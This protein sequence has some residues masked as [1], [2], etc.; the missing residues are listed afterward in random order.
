MQAIDLEIDVTEAVGL[1]GPVRVVA[2]VVLPDDLPDDP[3][4]CFAKPGGYGR[5]YF[6][7]DLPG[8]G[9]GAQAS[10]PAERGWVFV[11]VDPLGRGDSSQPADPDALTFTKVGAAN[12]AAAPAMAALDRRPRP[13]PRPWRGG[14]AKTGSTAFP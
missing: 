4:V 1:D 11:A 9:S 6:T 12:H 5:R 13:G 7:D 3:V 8:P 2:T 10:W 14:S